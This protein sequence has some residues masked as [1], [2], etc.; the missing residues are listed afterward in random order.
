MLPR[1]PGGAFMTTMRAV[2][3]LFALSACTTSAPD[4]VLAYVHGPDGYTIA[5]RA[6]PALEDPTRM[7]GSL[8]TVRHGGRL[9]LDD[10]ARYTGGAELAVRWQAVDGVAVPLDQDGLLLF[11]FYGHLS[12]AVDALDARGIDTSALFPIDLAWNPAVSP[13]IE[14]SPA[15]NAA[16]AIGSNLFLLL[17]DGDDRDVPLLANAG[18]VTH[19]LGHA[20]LHLLMT[21]DPLANAVTEDAT[22]QAG[23]WQASI[24]EGFAD[25][26][27]VL[28]LDDPAFMAPSIEMPSRDVEGSS[29]LTEGLLPENVVLEASALSIYDPYP[30]GTVFASTIW[31]VRLALD[32]PDATLALLVRAIGVWGPARAADLDGALFLDALVAAAESD[33]DIVAVCEAISGRFEAYHTPETCP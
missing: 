19:E 23:M 22:T 33:A 15:D 7:E 13:L 20:L 2:L 5:A 25:A 17:P 12:D 29:V 18:V 4:E 32:D 26:L 8:G 28:L 9:T 3:P 31:D 16:Y 6:L 24:H 11:S 10:A 1:P 30:L 21:G 27:A 14:L